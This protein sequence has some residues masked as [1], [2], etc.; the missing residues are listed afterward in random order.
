V[1]R[2]LIV[3]AA[4]LGG[5]VLALAG[6]G[7]GAPASPSGAERPASPSPTAPV[8]SQAVVSVAQSAL[9]E[10][11]VDAEGRTL[12]AFTK[13][14][15]GQ[16][17]C[18]GDCAA[19]WPAL[20]LTVQGV[21]AAGDGVQ[22]ALVALTDRRDGSAQVTYKGMPLYRFSGDQQPGDTNGQGVGGSWF[23][24]APDGALVRDAAQ[25]GNEGYQSNDGGY[26]SP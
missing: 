25:D 9:G 13:D 24:V 17:S 10:V 1:N 20:A 21:P 15:G 6:C 18:Y 8:G 7:G 19:T 3:M 16:S 22:A 26:G 12:Y 2:K 14:S 5:L 4:L 23:M 11:L